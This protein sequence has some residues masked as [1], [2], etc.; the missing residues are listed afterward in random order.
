M[1]SGPDGALYFVVARPGRVGIHQSR[2]GRGKNVIVGGNW[3]PYL[4]LGESVLEIVA[5]VFLRENTPALLPTA[6]EKRARASIRLVFARPKRESICSCRFG[7]RRGIWLA[8]IVH[9]DRCDCIL[10]RRIQGNRSEE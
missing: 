8:R 10:E 3:A 9:T 2:V 6:R 7:G 5:I 4:S 1:R